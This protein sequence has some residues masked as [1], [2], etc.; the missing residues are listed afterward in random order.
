MEF[1]VQCQLTICLHGECRKARAQN[2]NRLQ[3]LC[4]LSTASHQ[5]KTETLV[6]YGSLKDLGPTEVYEYCEVC[7]VTKCAASCGIG[8]RLFQ[9]SKSR[10]TTPTPTG[11]VV[12]VEKRPLPEANHI[13]QHFYVSYTDNHSQL[14]QQQEHFAVAFHTALEDAGFIGFSKNDPAKITMFDRGLG[15]KLTPEQKLLARMGERLTKLKTSAAVVICVSDEYLDSDCCQNEL[16][17]IDELRIQFL[18]VY[19][20]DNFNES[21]LREQYAQMESAA[22]QLILSRPW[23]GISYKTSDLSLRREFEELIQNIC[24]EYEPVQIETVQEEVVRG[25]VF[26]QK[27][28]E[29]GLALV[30]SARSGTGYVGVREISEA[31]FGARYLDK[32]GCGIQLGTFSTKEE[33]AL[34]VARALGPEESKRM[35]RMEARTVRIQQAHKKKAEEGKRGTRAMLRG[36]IKD[37]GMESEKLTAIQLHAPGAIFEGQ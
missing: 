27:A 16:Q 25:S 9:N 20:A 31:C 26:V 5:K 32:R 24:N 35:N 33:A 22:A 15:V 21:V 8:L 18:C 1:C 30:C 29:E 28:K 19:D 14:G 11:K 17:V 13:S 6:C 12:P 2:C 7:K 23:V 36:S 10:P 4:Y 37:S 34:A 3:H